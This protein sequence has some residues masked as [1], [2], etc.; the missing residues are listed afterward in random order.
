MAASDPFAYFSH[1]SI[2]P[3]Y[4][5]GFGRRVL[6]EQWVAH[7]GDHGKESTRGV[8]ADGAAN[9][10]VLHGVTEASIWGPTDVYQVRLPMPQGTQVLVQGEVLAGM[11]LDSPAV[12]GTKNEPRMPIAWTKPYSWQGGPEGRSFTTTMGASQDLLS[13]SLRRLLVNACYWA[14]GRASSIPESLDVSL[15]ESYQPTPFGFDKFRT[16]L[17]VSDFLPQD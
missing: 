8:I 1:D 6:G 17:Y 4:E 3:G 16:N 10:P 7:H 15:P 2:F 14:A 12:K 13:A 9:H 11:S 5:G